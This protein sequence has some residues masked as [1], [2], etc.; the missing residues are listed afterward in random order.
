MTKFLI[1]I[2]VTVTLIVTWSTVKVC[3]YNKRLDEET[4][5]INKLNKEETQL[6]VKAEVRYFKSINCN[7]S[8]I[9][10]NYNLE[11]LL[12]KI[13]KIFSDRY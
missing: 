3:Q 11:K 10:E 5:T 12:I 7:I 2:A 6:D 8:F 9:K 13:K 1:M 4:S